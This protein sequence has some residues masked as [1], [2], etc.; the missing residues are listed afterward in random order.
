MAEN[1]VI[2]CNCQSRLES[3]PWIE[4]SDI[5]NRLSDIDLLTITDLCGCG[6]LNPEK[7]VSLIDDARKILVVA[8][9]PRAVSLILN[10][11]GITNQER[12]SFFNLLEKKTDALITVA[13]DFRNSVPATSTKKELH[14]DPSWPSWYPVIDGQ[15]CNSCGQC[16]DF[17]LFGVYQKMDGKVAVINPKSCK[18]NCPACARICPR[19]AILFPKYGLGGAIGGSESGDETLEMKRLQQ[20]TDAIL[21]SDIY[22]ALEQRKMKRRMVIRED[23]MQQA[24]REREEA[25][26]NLKNE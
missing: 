4:T 12:I 18:N 3:Q 2:F 5:L 9:H 6:A 1:L 17:C 15:R 19:V 10:H 8:C 13:D 14:A 20:D 26:S 16:A 7:L 25:L 24:V 22:H 21:G 11:A 23:L